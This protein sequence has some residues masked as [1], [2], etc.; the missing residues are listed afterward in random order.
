MSSED[1]LGETNEAWK[2]PQTS[3]ARSVVVA[4]RH[5][6]PTPTSVTHQSTTC[7]CVPRQNGPIREQTQFVDVEMDVIEWVIV[8]TEIA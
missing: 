3:S 6:A 7:L 2:Q 8:W 5:N 1:V 4:D